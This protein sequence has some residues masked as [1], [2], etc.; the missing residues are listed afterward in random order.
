MEIENQESIKGTSERLG[1]IP[2]PFSFYIFSLI[3][4]TIYQNG[5]KFAA[6]LTHGNS[7]TQRLWKLQLQDYN[8][9]FSRGTRR[10][11][12]TLQLME[13]HLSLTVEHLVPHFLLNNTTFTT[14][15]F[16]STSI[17]YQ[18]QD[19]LFDVVSGSEKPQD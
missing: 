17:R 1:G 13:V 7:T 12:N 10:I 4:M 15:A 3:E 2:L 19:L 11:G 18:I 8:V 9:N 14:R 6:N 16:I 5:T